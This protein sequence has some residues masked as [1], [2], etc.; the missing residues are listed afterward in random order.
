MTDSG[1]LQ[2]SLAAMGF[3]ELGFALLAL[4]CYALAF[5][6]AL[7]LQV[8]TFAAAA[9]FVAAGAFAAFTDPWVHGVILIAIGIAGMGL[10]VAV[11][12]ALSAVLGLSRRGGSTEP[13]PELRPEEGTPGA[14][15]SVVRVAPKSALHHP[16]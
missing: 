7:G 10:F 8:R 15:P 14:A 6:G 13:I 1:S 9:A 5:N 4:C 16:S 3:I 11:V 12:W 2:D